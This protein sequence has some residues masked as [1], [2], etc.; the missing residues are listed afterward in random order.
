MKYEKNITWLA[1][2]I[3][4]REITEGRLLIKLMHEALK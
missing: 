4:R 1:H 2:Q 3:Y